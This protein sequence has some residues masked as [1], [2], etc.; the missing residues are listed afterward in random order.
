MLAAC[1]SSDGTMNVRLVDAPA[2]YQE[3]NLDV[4]KVDIHGE[5][6]WRT[7]GTP[8]QTVNLLSLTGGVS[9]VLVDGAPLPVGTYTQ[10]RL[11][12]GPANTVKLLDGTVHDLKVPSGMQSG[13]KLNARFDVAANMTKDVYIDFDAHRSIFLNRAGSSGQ[14]LLLPVVRAFDKLETGAVTGV[15]TDAVTRAPLAGVIVTAQTVDEGGTPS[16]VRSVNTGADGRYLLDLLPV[17][18]TYHVV[19]QPLAGGSAYLA[20]ASAPIAVTV[21]ASTPTYDAA[22]EP[23]SQVGAITGSIEPMADGDIVSAQQTLDA[24]ASPRTFIVRITTGVVA[25]G[26]ETYDLEDLPA[27]SY[28]VFVTRRTVDAGGTET[29]TTS[30]AVSATVEAGGTVTADLTLP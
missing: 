27:G 16:I 4:Q 7:L 26:A 1:G 15:L 12:L 13:V 2:D 10:M 20:R 14:Y 24:G 21:A 23:T 9:A 28:S 6:G 25:D 5:D 22:F 29:A 30:A 11:V 19:S 17:G 18:G 3:I 8:Q